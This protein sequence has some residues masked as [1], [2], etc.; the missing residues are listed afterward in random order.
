M[1][2][3]LRIRIFNFLHSPCVI[4]SLAAACLSLVI[5][6]VL[7]IVEMGGKIKEQRNRAEAAEVAM[8][9]VQD[10]MAYMLYVGGSAQ[11]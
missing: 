6:I 5:S 11:R 8:S 4:L 9:N 2:I 1:L 7:V 3:T 10:R